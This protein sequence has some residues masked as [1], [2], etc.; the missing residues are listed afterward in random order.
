MID[1][2]KLRG[3]LAEAGL[4][5]LELSRKL[6]MSP[7]TVYRKLNGVVAMTTPEVE[8]I[9]SECNTVRPN[10]FSTTDVVSVFFANLLT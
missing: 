4:S 2:T 8:A 7:T 9:I 3:K 5:G 1:Y 10:T 6:R